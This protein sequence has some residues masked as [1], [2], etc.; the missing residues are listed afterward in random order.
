MCKTRF[1][2]FP[3]TPPPPPLFSCTCTISYTARSRTSVWV[4]V[5]EVD[6]GRPLS[7]ASG[8]TAA[9]KTPYHF[10]STPAP[11]PLLRT[12]LKRVFQ[13]EQIDRDPLLPPFL[14]FH[15]W[16]AY[17]VTAARWLYRNYGFK[18]ISSSTRATNIGGGKPEQPLEERQLKSC[19]IRFNSDCIGIVVSWKWWSSDSNARLCFLTLLSSLNYFTGSTV[20]FFVNAVVFQEE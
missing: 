20:L 9:V 12:L 7:S 19:P 13:F 5:V 17:L 2:P 4:G 8:S 6:G 18:Y 11:L 16:D 1:Y 3:L 10:L 14:S 15:P